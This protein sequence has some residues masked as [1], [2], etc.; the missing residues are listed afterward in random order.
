MEMSQQTREPRVMG[1]YSHLTNEQ[2][3]AM[4]DKLVTS[5]TDRLTGPTSASTQG[6]A[7]AWQQRT[8]EI[9]REIQAINDELASRE[10]RS[11]HRPIYVV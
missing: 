3:V 5:L 7:V 8:D 9:R 2:L 10:G 6:R 1:I 4:R 11:T